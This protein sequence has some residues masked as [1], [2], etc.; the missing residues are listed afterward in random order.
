M[1]WDVAH[2][3][4]MGFPLTILRPSGAYSILSSLHKDMH[5][6]PRD[7]MGLLSA[8]NT[9]DAPLVGMRDL[10]AGMSGTLHDLS[11]AGLIVRCVGDGHG[12]P[13]RYDLTKLGAGLVRAVAPLTAWAMDDFD[14][15]VNATRTR[16][17]LPPF[18]GP[19]P[20]DLRRERTATGMAV[21]LL[22]RLWADTVMV[23]V[24]SAGCDG[25]NPLR[26][27]EAVNAAIEASNGASRV[28]RRLHRDT[29]Y[30]TLHS[31][32]AK[33]LLSRVEDPP[34]VRYLLTTH[35][36]GLMDAWWQVAE[37]WGIKNDAELFAIMQKTSGWFA[38]PSEG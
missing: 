2:H 16:L 33:R 21:T 4:G 5:L 23:Y 6:R 10:S 36:R 20:A 30:R 11:S 28:E 18:D 34:R 17:G 32:V 29:L 22:S 15:V 26:L 9:A 14:F 3:R 38:K 7:L 8:A 13:T 1:I 19:V 35:G 12:G 31:L 27:E 24:D 25:I 37:H